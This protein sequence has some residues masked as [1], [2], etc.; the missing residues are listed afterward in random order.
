[1][2]ERALIASGGCGNGIACFVDTKHPMTLDACAA[3]A[4]TARWQLPPEESRHAECVAVS[5]H[6][7]AAPV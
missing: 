4:F 5:L 7:V 3:A 1:M 2:P 6:A